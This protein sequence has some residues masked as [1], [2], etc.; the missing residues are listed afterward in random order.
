MRAPVRRLVLGL[1][2]SIAACGTPKGDPPSVKEPNPL[3][4]GLRIR[5]VQAPGMAPPASANAGSTLSVTS[6]VVTAIDTFD[7]TSDGKSRGTIYFQDA[8][9]ALPLGGVSAFSPSFQPANLRLFPGDVVDIHGQYVELHTLGTTV[10]FGAAF[11]PQ[12]DKPN[13]AFR[14]ETTRL[15]DPVAID[16]L[17]LFDFGKGRRWIGMLVKVTNLQ[18]LAATA[19]KGRVTYP[20]ISAIQNGPAISNELYDLKAG[21]LADGQTLQSVTGIVTF[22][23]N[24]KIAPRS[25]ADIVP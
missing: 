4:D 7:E 10:N 19:S 24:L 20:M 6:A 3:G 2:V 25:A 21:D 16:P 17:D 13:V 14:T 18:V 22:F 1:S 23:F 15:P 8:D 11:L 5:E 9:Q 12:F